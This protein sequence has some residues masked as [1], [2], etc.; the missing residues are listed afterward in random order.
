LEK[1]EIRDHGACDVDNVVGVLGTECTEPPPHAPAGLSDLGR[2]TRLGLGGEHGSSV[3][4]AAGKLTPQA[5]LEGVRNH[6]LERRIR[7]EE[8]IDLAGNGGSEQPSSSGVGARLA[9]E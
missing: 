6:L 4:T 1:A 2:L 7:N 8:V 9:S 3:A 5:A